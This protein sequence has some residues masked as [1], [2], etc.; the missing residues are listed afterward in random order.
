MDMNFPLSFPASSLQIQ[1]DD[2]VVLNSLS[3][4]PCI[5]VG[6]SGNYVL[7][8]F[9]GDDALRLIHYDHQ[10]DNLSS[11]GLDI[12]E[13][14]SRQLSDVCSIGLDD[15]LGKVFLVMGSGALCEL[16]YV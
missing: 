3:E 12:P 7:A 5:W 9:N 16:S 15:R 2:A 11:V 13:F 6:S 14:L 8:L 4:L 1:Y 10:I